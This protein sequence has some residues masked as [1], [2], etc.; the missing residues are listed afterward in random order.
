[1]LIIETAKIMTF[2]GIPSTI[3]MNNIPILTFVTF[4]KSFEYASSQWSS[5]GPK[6]I[7]EVFK[8][9]NRLDV[10]KPLNF[11]RLRLFNDSH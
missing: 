2:D 10:F 7:L 8:P 5:E 9:S 1:M 3:N 6:S 4:D 11:V